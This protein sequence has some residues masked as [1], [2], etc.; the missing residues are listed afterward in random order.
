MSVTQSAK[1]LAELEAQ[2]W[3]ET[4]L[5]MRKKGGIGASLYTPGSST[6]TYSITLRHE[7]FRVG[8]AADPLWAR[9]DS[10]MPLHT[11]VRIL[12]NTRI[13]CY[14][15]P[16]SVD[17]VI[18]EIDRYDASGRIGTV[19]SNQKPSDTPR[20]SKSE[21]PTATGAWDKIREGVEAIV[22]DRLQDAPEEARKQLKAEFD[23]ELRRAVS[24]LQSRVYLASK[25]RSTSIV[26]PVRKD[27]L[28]WCAVLHMDPPKSGQA[29][30]DKL[31]KKQF[32]SLSL[33]YHPDVNSQNPNRAEAQSR[34]SEAYHGLDKYNESLKENV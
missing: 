9:V 32:R 33:K 23:L 11:A 18:A 21:P 8:S 5:K 13:R 20:A 16:I 1:S 25:I 3:A 28:N 34:I 19:S 29:V 7:L 14:P 17:A 15:N 31:L 6:S 12:R 27:V 26:V 2:V 24:W 10:G 22:A 30:D 4:P